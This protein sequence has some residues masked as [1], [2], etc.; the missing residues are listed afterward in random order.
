MYFQKLL[1][2][3]TFVSNN[4]S[5]MKN[6]RKIIVLLTLC[7]T[8][9]G[10]S[11]FGQ[12][13]EK[14][15]NSP[16]TDEAY[17]ILQTVDGGFLIGGHIGI[18]NSTVKSTLI[19]LNA[20]GDTILTKRVGP[21]D[22]SSS[23]RTLEATND[24]GFISS[25]I[26]DTSSGDF[27]FLTKVDS[28]L[29]EVWIDTIF[30][31]QATLNGHAILPLPNGDILATGTTENISAGQNIDFDYYLI[32]TNSQG[33]TL[34]TLN[35]KDPLTS[36]QIYDIAPHSD[37][38]FILYG[39]TNEIGTTEEGTDLLLIKVSSEGEIIWEKKHD[40]G[41]VF[42]KSAQ[43]I[44]LPNN[45]FV[46][47]AGTPSRTL[48]TFDTTGDIIDEKIVGSLSLGSAYSYLNS[49]GSDGYIMVVSWGGSIELRRLNID[50]DFLWLKGFSVSNGVYNAS[51]VIPTTDN[52]FI[53][54]VK[55][56]FNSDDNIYLIKTDP[57]GNSLT[58]YLK[59]NVFFDN[60]ENCEFD[61]TEISLDNWI[62]SAEGENSTY[63]G[64]TDQ[65][66]NYE[67]RTDTGTY[68]L[69]LTAPNAYW[70]ACWED[71]S[72]TV[73]FPVQAEYDCPILNVD[74]STPFLR[75]CY[76]NTYYVSYCNEGTIIAE[77]ATI[78]VNFDEDLIINGS[79]LPWINQIDNTYTFDIDN[80]EVGECGGFQVFV[81]VDCDNA[82]LGETHCVEAHIYPDSICLPPNTLWDGSTIVVDGRCENDSLKFNI[83]NIGDD[84]I[85][86]AGFIVIED[87]ILHLNGNFH[88]DTGDSLAVSFEGTGATYRLEAEQAEG[89]PT[90]T[91]PS[92]TIEGCSDNTQPISL[93]FVNSYSENDADPFVS[94]DCQQN[95]GSFDPNDKRG[96]PEGIGEEHIIFHDTELEYHIRFQNTGTDTAFLVV[97]RDT[98]SPFLDLTSLQPGASSH[99]YTWELQNER[100]LKFTFDNIMLPDSNI[101]EVASHG[102][103]KFRINQELDNIPGT[104]IQNQAGIYF[105]FNEPVITNQTAHKIE[106]RP[107]F[108]DTLTLLLCDSEQY[109][110]DT[111]VIDFSSQLSWDLTTTNL[112]MVNSSSQM[113]LDTTIMIGDLFQGIEYE[114]DTTLVQQYISEEGC[115]STI[116]IHLELIPS[117]TNNL[118]AAIEKLSL[119]PNPSSN[120][121][122][123]LIKMKQ[124]SPLNISILNNLGQKIE[125]VRYQT[126]MNTEE[127][128]IPIPILNLPNGIY[129]VK[130][131]SGNNIRMLKLAKQ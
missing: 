3:L 122:N 8:V 72:L 103:V 49:L 12:G 127:Q 58:N 32:K 40:Y 84:M 5:K 65:F 106:D 96:F 123:L 116:I 6:L 79:S 46:G 18:D 22:F 86:P 92:I 110:Q 89:H 68:N 29:N 117:A 1:L 125:E 69:H 99:P 60:L 19:K 11:A 45:T 33:D 66:G 53:I 59:G 17:R 80:V 105:D 43:L 15:L 48:I 47:L 42:A 130:I 83:R 56:S 28:A 109:E 76:D 75:R 93:G 128:V 104:L 50:G 91:A 23:L 114:M 129:W 25:G 38:S 57:F 10:G 131:K 21:I 20:E 37:G 54:I 27:I 55:K 35:A 78:E 81:T 82:E 85:Q 7:L 121:V 97:I 119:F 90:N 71:S 73:D 95:I 88:L 24:G 74:I 111:T 113:E 41:S 36:K 26:W 108:G 9:F 13:W 102:F 124:A 115:D 4:E 118:Y 14:E 39:H 112:I 63:H 34:W 94:R 100:A 31:G 107:L 51:Q 77:N 67:I 61:P 52:N 98:L 101:N 44:S 30:F 62:L 87:H 2:I 120:Q 126:L 16:F 64:I 70:N